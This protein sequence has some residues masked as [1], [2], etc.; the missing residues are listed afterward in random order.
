[1]A[2]DLSK[3]VTTPIPTAGAVQPEKPIDQLKEVE[4]LMYAATKNKASDLHLKAGQKPI[5]RV[6]TVIHEIGSRALSGDD[7]RRI[8]YE[9]MTE[10]QR[11][12]FETEH[13]LDFAYSL[14]GVGRFRVN[15]FAERGSVA[16]A[17]RR[18]N[19]SIPTFNDLFLPPE[20]AKITDFEQGLVIVAGPTGSGKSTTLA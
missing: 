3:A 1:M 12:R 4:R 18:V 13:D 5:L 16:V 2:D 6:N 14:A 17:A 11:D 19:T 10:Q 20:V 9:I 7:V 8:M 15:V